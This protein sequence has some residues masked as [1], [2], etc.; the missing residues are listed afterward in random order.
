MTTLNNYSP[1]SHPNKLIVTVITKKLTRKLY[2]Y[3][4]KEQARFRA[5]FNSNGHQQNIN[6]N[7]KKP[8]VQNTIDSK[9]LDGENVFKQTAII[10]VKLHENANT[11]YVKTED[12]NKEM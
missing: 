7:K 5:G 11:I 9:F 2:F 1:K 6:I 8:C 4:I 3:Q 12:C 10:S